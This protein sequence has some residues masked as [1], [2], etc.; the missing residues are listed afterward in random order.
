MLNVLFYVRLISLEYKVG[1]L[2]FNRSQWAPRLVIFSANEVIIKL[3]I[4]HFVEER[5]NVRKKPIPLI[6]CGF[7]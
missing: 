4:E 7:Y 5:S 1:Q 6:T 2:L 3:F